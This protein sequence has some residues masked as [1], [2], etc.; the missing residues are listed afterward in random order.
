MSLFR[1]FERHND[2]MK[3]H[4]STACGIMRAGRTWESELRRDEVYVRAPGASTI[5]SARDSKFL[6]RMIKIRTEYEAR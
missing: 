2:E 1:S 4:C 5:E 3:A 6:D